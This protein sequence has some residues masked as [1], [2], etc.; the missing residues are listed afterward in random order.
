MTSRPKCVYVRRPGIGNLTKS[1]LQFTKIPITGTVRTVRDLCGELSIVIPDQGVAQ[2]VIDLNLIWLAGSWFVC[3]AGPAPGTQ[4]LLNDEALVVRQSL[5][6]L[7]Q[8]SDK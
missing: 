7:A 5:I 4:P 2:E 8:M 6:T 1:G 3:V